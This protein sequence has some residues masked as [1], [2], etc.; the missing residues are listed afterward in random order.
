MADK[1]GEAYF[2]LK[3]KGDILEQI[4]DQQRR[5]QANQS[6]LWIGG[7]PGGSSS[8]PG[9][10]S[11]I[12]PGAYAGVQNRHW[13]A[14]WSPG[15]WGGPPAG[16]LAANPSMPNQ[17]G[18]FQYGQHPRMGDIKDW[19]GIKSLGLDTSLRSLSSG[20]ASV[21]IAFTALAATFLAFT[22]AASP[23]RFAT[24][25]G[26]LTMAAMSIGE[27][28]LPA[29]DRMSNFLQKVSGVIDLIP[30]ENSFD[31]RYPGQVQH[32]PIMGMPQSTAGGAVEW[33]RNRFQG[34]G[35]GDYLQGVVVTGN[36]MEK[37]INDWLTSHGM[38]FLSS[39]TQQ[40]NEDMLRSIHGLP[41]PQFSTFS[42]YA[43]RLAVA[44]LQAGTLEGTI[45]ARQLQAALDA[46][47]KLNLLNDINAGIQ[48]IQM[49]WRN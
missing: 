1:V 2:D 34:T 13:A 38:G 36:Q 24:F 20:I 19:T 40:V 44:G 29:L 7:G 8:G 23:N 49:V 41:Q 46:N 3:L 35:V 5:V 33:L 42:Q 26:S 11:P 4:R 25:T 45:E 9:G 12:W 47:E 27:K 37:S 32:N 22:A 10:G 43:D 28:F 18:N 17:I 30:G 21:S 15:S 31:P 14:P 6:N 39:N 48:G 16:S